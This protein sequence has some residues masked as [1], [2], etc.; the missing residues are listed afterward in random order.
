[1]T[2]ALIVVDVQKDFC[3]EARWRWPGCG[4]RGTDQ[5]AAR[6]RSSLRRGGGHP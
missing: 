6:G 5:R 3:E 1:M 2:T 4:R